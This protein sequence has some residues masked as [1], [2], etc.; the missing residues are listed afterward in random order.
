MTHLKR[1]G[2][3]IAALLLI[4]FILA[5]S[6][7]IWLVRHPWTPVAGDVEI[8]GLNMT[9][10]IARDPWGV[11]HIYAQNEADLLFAQGYV[12]AQDRLWQMEIS[13]RL[14]QGRMSEIAGPS[15]I[16]VDQFMR[17]LGLRRVAEQSWQEMDD[18][19][20]AVLTAYAAGV[21]AYLTD[22]H[23][24]L[25]IEYT[26]MG[27]EPQPWTPL[28]SLA[29][30][31]F[32]S[33][34]MGVN[35]ALELLQARTVAEQGA[36]VLTQLFLFAD[37]LDPLIVPPEA[38]NYDGLRAV[39]SESSTSSTN[40][41]MKPYPSWASN[42]WVVHGNRTATGLP[43]L[44][45]DT[46]L[47]LLM[48]SVWYQ[49]GL[50]GGRFNTVGFTLPGVPLVVIGHN[51][52]IAWGITN[53]G[54]D[55]QDIYI[56]HLNDLNN[57]TQYQYRGEWRD[58]TTIPET[59]L[60]KDA[61]PVAF[62]VYLTQHGPLINDIFNVPAQ[63]PV[64]LRWAL[65]EGNAVLRSILMLNV[66][67]NWDEF[68]GAIQYWDSPNVNFV[69]ADIAGNIG[70]QSAGR[71]PIRTA[72]HQGA[73]PV[74]G[75]TGDYEWVTFIPF[76][77]LPNVLNPDAG[78]IATANNEFV[79]HE[80]PYMLTYDW[81]EPSYRADQIAAS[82]AANQNHSLTDSA[83]LQLQ[84]FSP[85]AAALQPYLSVIEPADQQ[86]EDA[87]SQVKVWDFQYQPEAIGATVYEIWYL[88]MLYY[89][90]EDELGEELM[91]EY[92]QYA[93]KHVPMMV[94]LMAEA[95][96]AW[97]D[98]MNTPETETRDDIVR[99]AWP[100]ALIWL[101]ERYGPDVNDWAW[102]K[103]HTTTFRHIPIGQSGIALLESLFNSKTYPSPGA[104][105]SVNVGWYDDPFDVVFGPSQR[106]ILDLSN[107]DN[108]SSVNSTGQNANLFHAH[109]QDLSKMWQQGDYF[110]MLFTQSS[111]Q[112][113]AKTVLTLR[114][115]PA[116]ENP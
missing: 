72:A 63:Q 25:P 46:H 81:Y 53:M 88:H 6:V 57:P 50:H 71:V 36:S 93:N 115:S 11:P 34:N 62:N 13:R 23:N 22:N 65:Y 59:I 73:L 39:P 98:D 99:R 30:G 4:L 24:R 68:R 40:W 5:S 52:N 67:S 112:A 1:W 106:M 10:E 31:N 100:D 91:D 104:Q 9:V 66:A 84:T 8:A 28:D 42:N 35:A 82:L 94:Q 26:L 83:A 105:F 78:F 80:Y 109:R 86:E 3:R 7:G 64:S 27:F 2:I 113:R 60:V 38:N 48:P 89:T 16:D 18:D 20:R 95:D 90:F 37:N 69:Y 92:A 54:P 96:N 41:L 32:L 29:W 56:E 51:Q 61:E 107:F 15:T 87:L 49:N 43:I 102:A 21:N 58:L 103:V 55:V 114:P 14:S 74:P 45:N 77:E 110:P 85:P 76:T 19:A 101:Q 108:S 12:H 111:V 47:D 70:Q 44:A 116:T 79:T 97:F 17:T 33:L 75:W